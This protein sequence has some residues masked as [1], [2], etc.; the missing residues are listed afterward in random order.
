MRDLCPACRRE[1][2]YGDPRAVFGRACFECEAKERVKMD[3]EQAL[4]DAE[5]ALRNGDRPTALDRL[6]GY[7][8]WRDAGG[9]EPRNGDERAKV[10]AFAYHR[11]YL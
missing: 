4:K 1:Y 2:P 8:A 6:N 9:F 10:L 7:W 11:G 3:P 5:S